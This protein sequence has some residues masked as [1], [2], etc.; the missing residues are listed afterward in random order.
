MPALRLVA[1]IGAVFAA[2]FLLI[3]IFVWASIWWADGSGKAFEQAR[4]DSFGMIILLGLI[5][6]GATASWLIARLQSRKA[7]PHNGGTAS[8]IQKVI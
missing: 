2:L 3:R 7:F 8:Q 1:R 4:S 5:V 6:V